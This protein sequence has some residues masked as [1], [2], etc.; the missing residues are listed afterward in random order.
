MQPDRRHVLSCCRG[1]SFR[2]PLV[3]SP[4]LLPTMHPSRFGVL[5]PGRVAVLAY[6]TPTP[7]AVAYELSVL[8]RARRNASPCIA[9]CR[10]SVT[11]RH[12]YVVCSPPRAP[13][14]ASFA[15]LRV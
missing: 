6:P 10:L 4:C 12:H 13:R 2:P 9:A 14:P 15:M 11:H 3:T 7:C 5:A 8:R 1:E